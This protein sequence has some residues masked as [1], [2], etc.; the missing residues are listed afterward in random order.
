MNLFHLPG[1]GFFVSL[2]GVCDELFALPDPPDGIVPF[3]LAYGS[4]ELLTDLLIGD[5]DATGLLIV[6]QISQVDQ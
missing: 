3:Y 1:N 6:S 2:D 5:V 4:G